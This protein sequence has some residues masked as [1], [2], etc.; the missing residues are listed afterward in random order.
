MRSRTFER[1]ALLVLT[2]ACVACAGSHGELLRQRLDERTTLVTTGLT[3]P[4]VLYRE[5]PQLA[6]NARDYIQLG[7]MEVNRQGNL[8]YYLWLGTW[9]TIDR[10]AGDRAASAFDRAYL[11]VDG[12][13]MELMAG[14]GPAFDARDLRFYDEPVRSTVNGF[15]PV[16]ADQLRRL[17]A[18]SDVYLVLGADERGR[19]ETWKWNPQAL[20]AFAQYADDRQLR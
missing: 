6:A 12:E 7:P 1:I 15:Y 8:S 11:F 10:G 16:T 4:L 2:G 9:S 20:S 13:P 17:G 3:E 14:P 19:Y 5:Q 18:A